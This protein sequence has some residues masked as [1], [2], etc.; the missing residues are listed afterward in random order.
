[1]LYMRH[2]QLGIGT[3][4]ML[5][6]S[7]GQAQRLVI[8]E[9]PP[10]EV[11]AHNNALWKET[12]K[13]NST[14]VM[15][16]EEYFASEAAEYRFVVTNPTA[17]PVD[18]VEPFH[19]IAGGADI[20]RLLPPGSATKRQNLWSEPA[21]GRVLF[22]TR[23]LPSRRLNPGESIEFKLPLADGSCPTTIFRCGIPNVPG[24]YEIEY[25][26]GRSTPTVFRVVAP[27]LRLLTDVPFQ[28]RSESPERDFHGNLTGKTLL[29]PR[30]V[31]VAVLQH[32]NQYY[33]VAGK[34]PFANSA[35]I[36]PGELVRN[37]IHDYVRL[38]STDRMITSIQASADSAEN[39]TITYVDQDGKQTV[40]RLDP[41]RKPVK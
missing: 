24:D 26:Y 22:E 40:I 4:L 37:Q 18:V 30:V 34:I 27:T 21:G 39:I 11:L 12:A 29:F 7:L 10:P 8:I 20:Y 2:L 5:L 14:V 25:S 33:V 35:D 19:S 17:L 9:Q 1:M 36:K 41:S 6:S 15:D 3:G 28:R 38:A 13:L 23:R 16:R 32:G 31:P